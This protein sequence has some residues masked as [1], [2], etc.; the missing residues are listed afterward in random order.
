MKSTTI[1]AKRLLTVL[2]VALVITAMVGIMA[3]ADEL[4][5]FSL[6]ATSI[7][8]NQ[9]AG[10][11]VG[12]LTQT[13][14]T[15]A[16]TGYSLPAGQGDNTCFSIAVD[17]LIT[18]SEFDYETQ[19]SYT[20]V[21]EATDGTD[22]A[23]Q[24]FTISVVNVNEYAP[25]TSDT[26][27]SVAEDESASL[28]LSASDRDDDDLLWSAGS[29][30]HGTVSISG[31]TLTY[32]PDA[33]YFGADSITVT[34]SD[35][36]YS[37][38]ATVT[39][40]VSP[41]NDAPINTAVPSVSGTAH[42]GQTLIGN[43]GSWNDSLDDS[44]ATELNYT[45][46]W[47]SANSS[48]GSWS[49]IGGATETSYTLT[50]AENDKYIRLGVTCTDSDTNPLSTTA[51][52]AAMTVENASPV[53]SEGAAGSLAV[54]EDGAAVTLTL[55]ASDTDGNTLSWSITDAP[56]L[57]SVQITGDAEKTVSYTPSL[58]A[59]GSDSFVITV[60]DGNG[61]TAA[62]TV[63]VTVTAVNDSP[64]F[65]PGSNVTVDEDSGAY[66]ASWATT[67]SK[68]PAN[69]S[70]QSLTFDVSN[71]NNTLF[72]LQPAI[73]DDGTL[74]FTPAANANGSAR[75]TVTLTDSEMAATDSISF[76]ITVDA[77]NDTP[78]NTIAPSVTGTWSVGGALTAGSGTWSDTA[79][80]GSSITCSYSW[81]SAS[82]TSGSDL[83]TIGAEHTYTLTAAESHRYVRVLVTAT[84][85]DASGTV[86]AQA[87]LDWALVTNS[88]PVVTEDT[89]EL[90][91]PEDSHD[92]LSITLHATDADGD[93]LTWSASDGAHG[94][95]SASGA[96]FAYTPEANYFGSDSFTVTVSDGTATDSITVTVTVTPVNDAPV[97]TTAP[98]VLG[99]AHNGQSLTADPGSW[100][101][102]LD[103]S[104]ASALNYAYQ[105]QSAD[106]SGAT[107][108]DISDAND[109]AYILTL[110][111]ND[112]YI[113]AVVTCT[114]SDTT[115]LST[116]AS[117]APVLVTNAAPVITEGTSGALTVLEDGSAVSLTLNGSDAD[118]DTLSWSVTT[119]PS[120]GSA[121]IT[122]D[123]EKTVSY[124][125]D[126]NTNGGDSF[127]VT[128]SDVN[129]ASDTYTVSVT[130]TE[131]N[132]LPVITGG[133]TITTDEDTPFPYLFTVSDVEDSAA[134]LS[135][136]YKTGSTAFLPQSGMELTADGGSRTLTLT[137]VTD[138]SG[139]VNV[140]ITVTDSDGGSVTKIIPMTINAVD[141]PPAISSI[142]DRTIDED[143]STGAIGFALS[144]VDSDLNLCTVTATSGNPALIPNDVTHIVPGGTG[145]NRT[146]TLTP[147]DNA[148]GDAVITITVDDQDG[149]ATTATF[150][151]HVNA[152][153][154]APQISVIAN[155]TIDEDQPGGTGDI[156]FT[157]SD[158]DNNVSSL[159]VTAATDNTSMIPRANITLDSTGSDM[160]IC[161][162][163]VANSYG[164]A[165]ITVTVKDP[166]GKLAAASLTLTVN[167]VNDAPT[168][169]MD[170]SRTINED[171]TSTVTVTVSDIDTPLS[172][173]DLHAVSSTNTTLLPLA[174]INIPS[175]TTGTRTL[176][177][178]PAADESGTAV[179][180]LKL[181]DGEGGTVTKTVT[182]NV[183]TV[184]DPPTFTVGAD[185]T[186]V[187]DFGA[188]TKS[189][190][191]T[192]ITTG[193][194]NETQDL[195]FTLTTDND[196][197]FAATPTIDPS[198]GDLTCTLTA[199]ANG[200]ANVTAVLRDSGG[201]TITHT[202]V[203]TVTAV[204]DT[205][206]AES[207]TLPLNTNE[208]QVLKGALHATDVDAGDTLRFEL[209]T[210]DGSTHNLT[211]AST[212]HGSVTINSATGIFT[213]TP[214][215]D[216]FGTTDSFDFRVYDGTVYSNTATITIQ[217]TGVNDPPIA[218][219]SSF[220]VGEDSAYTGVL[221]SATDVDNSSLTYE[222]I[223]DS[224]H[225]ALT[226][227]S[228]GSVAYTPNGNFYGTD[229]FTYRA[230]DGYIYSN[231]ATVIITVTPVND[232]PTAANETIYLDEGNTLHGVLKASDLENNALTYTV[233]TQPASGSTITADA[234]TGKY[235]YTPAAL[236]SGATSQTVSF[237]FR[238]EDGHGS[239]DTGMVTIIIRNVNNAPDEEVPPIIFTVAEDGTLAGNVRTY[240]TDGDDLTYT[241]VSTVSHGTISAIDPDDGSFTYTPNANF[242]GTD[243]F[244]FKADDSEL[245]T[246]V[247][248][249]IINVTS[250]NDTPVVYN[251]SYETAK[252]TPLTGIT[253]A[254][255]DID[256]DILTYSVTPD[257]THGT[258]TQTANGVYTYTPDGTY[259]GNDTFL[260]TATDSHGAKS[261]EATITIHVYGSGGSYSG[262]DSISN[263]TIPE[264]TSATVPLTITGI[265]ISSVNAV[266]SNEWLLP[267]TAA[268][269]QVLE[270]SG[271]YSLLLT[272]VLHRTGCTVITV[273]VTGTDSNTYSRTFVLT[274][275][276]VNHTPTANSKG[277]LEVDEGKL[278]Y[279]FVTGSD[280]NGDGLSYTLVQTTA[281]GTLD[282]SNFA[283]DGTF[284]YDSD[285]GF[286]GSDSFTFTVTDG[287]Y[288]SDAATLSISVRQVNTAPTASS[289]AVS[290]NE[291][292][293]VSGTLSATESHGG[294]LTYSVVTAPSLGTVTLDPATGG[295]TY[296]P[297][298]NRNGTDVFTFKAVG[299]TGLSS[300]TASITI[301]I[302]PVNDKPSAVAK[303]VSTHEDQPVSGYLE[304]TDV[305][306][307]A[308][309]YS[310]ANTEGDDSLQK[311]SV[312]IHASTG[313]FAYTPA[314]NAYGSDFFFFKVYDGE[315]YSDPVKITVDI[316]EI[317]DAPIAYDKDDITV[318][319]DS[320]VTGSLSAL[321][322]DVDGDNQTF[323][324]I[325][326][327][328]KGII[329][330]NTDGTFT[331]TP[332]ANVNGTDYFSFRTL[333]ARGLYSNV[334]LVTITITP[335]NDTPT[336]TAAATD[337][338]KEDSSGG[339]SD[340]VFYFTVG[341]I[342]DAAGT[343]SVGVEYNSA[344]ISSVT[345]GGSG[346]SRWIKVMP[347]R[348]FK[349]NT[350]I[351]LIVTD[352]GNDGTLTGDVKTAE[353]T[354]TF[355]VVPV[356]DTPT[357]NG[358]ETNGTKLHDTVTIDEDTST[359]TVVPDGIAFIIGDEETDASA[360]TVTATSNNTTV[361]PQT[362]SN[363]ILGGSGSDCTL[364]VV[365][366]ADKSGTAT[367]TVRVSD[368]ASTRTA[369]VTVV[370]T[371]VN[372]A[373]VVTPPNDPDELTIPE[374]G[375]TEILYYIISDIDSDVT[376]ITMTPSSSEENIVKPE[377]IVLSGNGAERTVQITPEADAYGDVT[378]TLRADDHGAVNRYGT[379]SFVLH[380][381]AVNDPPV[382][383]TIPNQETDEDHSISNIPLT[384]SDIDSNV[385]AITYSAISGNTGLI[386]S[387]GVLFDT[388]PDTGAPRMTLTPKDDQNGEA[389][390]TIKA[391]DS[392]GK[393][394]TTSFKLT[395]NPVNDA[396]TITNISEQTILE[397][398]ATGT[399]TF[400]V[401]DVDNDA[402]TLNVTKVSSDTD[403][404]PTANIVLSG[405]GSEQMVKVTP[406]ADQNG[407][408]SITLRVTDPD[409]LYN[410]SILVLNITP[411]ND[412]PSFIAGSDVTV[413]EDSGTHSAGW[414]TG[415]FKGPDN[416]DAQELTFLVTST[417]DDLFETGKTPTITDDGT[418]TFTPV[419]DAFGTSG[420]T[421]YLQ[422]DG[423]T[424][425]GGVDQTAV[426]VTFTITINS[427]L[428]SPSIRSTTSLSSPTAAT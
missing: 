341:D 85:T 179:V 244:T 72:V 177:L 250:V 148:Y 187:E 416:E 274:V 137:P 295:F 234:S 394:T 403:I 349:G 230:Y 404:V 270:D 231:T 112:K 272:P 83:R 10:T 346:D 288:T 381:T 410:E 232:A 329:E 120:L 292:T 278:L 3:S 304:G 348:H 195:T 52:S 119:P 75:V 414:V 226:L 281:H 356:N 123:G 69:E 215:P 68:G 55:N 46:V 20:V 113:R 140:T 164:T 27:L 43:I 192:D 330:F 70:D 142:A 45:Y 217:I 95:V 90:T 323:Y 210:G 139:T 198:T 16:I 235:T 206:A 15:T 389:L 96:T 216:Y 379:G 81:Q 150:T 87:F 158:V 374:D 51:Y 339:D 223:H 82:D 376:A 407:T 174:S 328:T 125:P 186:V 284:L 336:I 151:V 94:D 147:L 266:S 413:D 49:S 245:Y 334:A 360:L 345:T 239:S 297:Y 209:V 391:T 219:D 61:G 316:E 50:P 390:I 351:K 93:T 156:S 428:P 294:A 333:D 383:V 111:E 393:W 337:S 384:V 372:D 263:R 101:D 162:M 98:L 371:P 207:I 12:P 276:R 271:S 99:T 144:D 420:V 359:D 35:G 154:D 321:Y 318:A 213:Y 310:L 224:E 227:S 183:N 277:P 311:G 375:A 121:Q 110:A 258:L 238:A 338:I 33:N 196:A 268:G 60:S 134:S 261:A 296:S 107:W 178:T 425:N 280:L 382:I 291:D 243:R 109:S 19:N 309:T 48:E 136:T 422:D 229:R 327:P 78:V 398:S 400:R 378:I 1:Y 408:V 264:D 367:I 126:P 141:D 373:P 350:N 127:V 286:S 421:V 7:Q 29:A 254:G 405:A 58:D 34:V 208:E 415:I 282:T 315:Y 131:V 100:N 343:L 79:D 155:Q 364:K 241:V 236:P 301:T 320:S 77:V 88:A 17:K 247:F 299:P 303:S 194:A 166:G 342:E 117:S 66:S 8:E 221:N 293:A 353:H 138:K 143:H 418:L 31:G 222:V 242:N 424:A 185:E 153:N 366:A 71:N 426:A 97:N 197:M 57:G 188:V 191:A 427:P 128:V 412:I 67:V 4:V 37:D 89:A 118:G 108:S 104:M 308:L 358:Y 25:E 47:Q 406:A 325:Q 22:T 63:S 357:I 225:G 252:D 419:A 283:S 262:L 269:I 417:N 115:P 388:D 180:E 189:A 56:A 26:S 41:A 355:T 205:P 6:D 256:G 124:T 181:D 59:N 369:Y 203:I 184:N 347:V 387:S 352:S 201:A 319:E 228:D 401:S 13:S 314:D 251:Q 255:Y 365:P 163:P 114:D 273:T 380:I 287:D 324:T 9:I 240:D 84:D 290:T 171:G 5:D 170:S 24:S 402:T 168:I 363:L 106:S 161:V 135:V 40:T 377:N 259:E 317:N 257:P 326:A 21:I 53:I 28:T 246:S 80:T 204:N 396:P 74:T 157:I 298:A 165:Q 307:S 11:E 200:V 182:L 361:V 116:V 332:T 105:W 300:D 86:T 285:D 322:S 159:S 172:E 253:L 354:V 199:N 42:N 173:L 289:D 65:I 39:I 275:T 392:D 249:T 344:E 103:S 132:D 370:V 145:A 362:A 411:V 18:N 397:D 395:V 313:A 214:S 92:I 335:V 218:S 260:Y 176:T 220:T 399:L 312:S 409:G 193:A 190:W 279:E 340:N 267:N 32:I 130:V 44:L 211:T 386:D 305:E 237:T 306:Y 175:G 160:T 233:L 76:T 14:G 302:V 169:S 23:R 36:T 73:A 62:Y 202:F 212:N 149:E 54:A 368:G 30:A 385:S 331:Y 102:T 2:A 265:T 167:E 152:V 91:V 423:G 38:M 133:D 129:G 64:S 248:M 146:I 122:G